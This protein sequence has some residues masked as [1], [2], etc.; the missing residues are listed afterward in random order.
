MTN[1]LPRTTCSSSEMFFFSFGSS[2][3]RLLRNVRK[4]T[5]LCQEASRLV[6]WVGPGEPPKQNMG[7]GKTYGTFIILYLY[8]YMCIH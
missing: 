6:T 4:D 1:V 5:A 3:L 8:E 2:G 7:F